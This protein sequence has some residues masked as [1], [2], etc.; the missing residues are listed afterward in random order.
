M[1]G[2][3]PQISYPEGYFELQMTN[4][5]TNQKI[6]EFMSVIVNPPG[7]SLEVKVYVVVEVNS[8]ELQRRWF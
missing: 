8:C 5:K 6:I 2:R 1:V 7:K 3:F 4:E